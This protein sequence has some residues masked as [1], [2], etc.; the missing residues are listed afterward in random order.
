ML[1]PICTYGKDVDI[2]ATDTL[3]RGE[4][5]GW[6]HKPGL[7]PPKPDPQSKPLYGTVCALSITIVVC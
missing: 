1:I 7:N 5:D 2:L 3:N 6:A 4:W